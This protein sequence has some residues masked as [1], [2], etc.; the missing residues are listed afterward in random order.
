MSQ[1]EQ[2]TLQLT[3][4]PCD[5]KFPILEAY[6]TRDPVLERVQS[7]IAADDV[8]VAP[9]RDG[10]QGLGFTWLAARDEGLGYIQDNGKENGNCYNGF[11]GVYI[12]I[13]GYVWG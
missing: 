6:A 8:Q 5:Q 7:A 13:I 12:G 10:D 2:Q 11:Y 4:V 3:V 1:T 9:P